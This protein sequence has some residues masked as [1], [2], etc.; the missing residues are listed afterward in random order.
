MVTPMKYK[1]SRN[2]DLFLYLCV[3]YYIYLEMYYVILLKSRK[4]CGDG[5]KFVI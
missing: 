5:V 1:K 4:I 2:F 3:T